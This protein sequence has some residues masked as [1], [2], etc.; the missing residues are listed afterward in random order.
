[1]NIQTSVQIIINVDVERVFDY[2]IDCQNLPMLFTG[3]QSI[4]AILSA[5]TT[6]GLPLQEGSMRI[7][8]NSDG[9]AIAEII[10][11]LQRPSVQAYK[12]IQGFKPPFAWLVHSASGKWLYN[13]TNSATHITWTFEFKMQHLLAYLFFLAVVKRPFQTA[14]RICLENLKRLIEERDRCELS[15][16]SDFSK[17]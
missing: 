4:P 13:A 12:L 9:S 17:K 14:Q 1:M 6:D 3:Y 10:T 11:I 2:S 7:V 15:V 16:T 8:N 5:S